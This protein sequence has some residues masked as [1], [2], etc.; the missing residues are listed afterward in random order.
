MAYVPP[1]RRCNAEV[2]SENSQA[3]SGRRFAQSMGLTHANLQAR[4]ESRPLPAP[5]SDETAS[6]ATSAISYRSTRHSHDRRE[7]RHV[8]QHDIKA[9]LKHGLREPS[10]RGFQ[11]EYNGLVVITAA[12]QKRIV[13]TYRKFD[14][15]QR[16]ET[17]RDIN[18]SL[19]PDLA[20]HK[21][22]PFAASRI[23]PANAARYAARFMES[24]KH[25]YQQM[26]YPEALTLLLDL[27]CG[28]LEQAL[29]LTTITEP[30]W[31]CEELTRV[32][33]KIESQDAPHPR[34]LALLQCAAAESSLPAVFPW[35]DAA[36]D[37]ISLDALRALIEAQGGVERC[38]TDLTDRNLLHIYCHNQNVEAVEL[39]LSVSD[40]AVIN[41][42]NTHGRPPI[43]S[44]A[45]GFN[46]RKATVLTRRLSRAS[47][48]WHDDNG[49]NLL[50]HV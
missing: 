33:R 24:L 14:V 43:F 17:L 7:Q 31:S 20:A 30:C 38:G 11:F 49:R 23:G 8:D 35:A 32:L 5:D 26:R 50:H 47:L 1:H 13:T 27:G 40:D 29:Q 16:K 36:N 3:D 44:A 9:V 19:N 18:D 41:A 4:R 2:P 28:A 46:A 39:I 42:P 12:D 37:V 10:R 15:R 21:H 34:K 25:G 22:G 45:G 48:D 6:V